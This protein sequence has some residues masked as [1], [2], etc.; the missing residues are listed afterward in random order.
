MS[1]GYMFDIDLLTILMCTSVISNMSY[2]I[3]T[4][5]MVLALYH[6]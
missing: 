4:S 6:F 1:E 5:N 2:S 3:L